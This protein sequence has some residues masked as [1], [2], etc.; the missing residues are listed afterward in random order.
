[1]NDTELLDYLQNR[2]AE[3]EPHPNGDEMLWCVTDGEGFWHKHTDIRQAIRMAIK[4]DALSRPQTG[5]EKFGMD[6]WSG[7]VP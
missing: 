4:E 2:C 6:L 7:C 3:L 1:M 5:A